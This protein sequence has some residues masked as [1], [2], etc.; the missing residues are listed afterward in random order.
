M[1]V[2]FFASAASTPLLTRYLNTEYPML[3]DKIERVLLLIGVIMTL[4]RFPIPVPIKFACSL[5]ASLNYL[6]TVPWLTGSY[7]PT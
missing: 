4:L 3:G 1:S 6:P 7:H 5:H 2:G